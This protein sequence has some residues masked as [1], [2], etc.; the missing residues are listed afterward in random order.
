MADVSI[1]SK[2][3]SCY[4]GEA[5]FLSQSGDATSGGGQSCLGTEP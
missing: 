5:L 3:G 1:L 4:V 2:A